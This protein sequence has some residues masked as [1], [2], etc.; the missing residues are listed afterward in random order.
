MKE[1]VSIVLQNINKCV[2]LHHNYFW[3]T[4][5]LY[6]E[7][8]HLPVNSTLQGGKYRIV[9]FIKSGGFGCTYEAVDTLMNV[10]VAIKEFFVKDFCNRDETTY[11]IT[12]ATESKRELVEKLRR[13]FIDEARAIF[14]MK[15]ENIVRVYGVFEENGTAYYVMDYID[16]PSLE[17]IVKQYGFLSETEA[18]GYIRQVAGA[19]CYVHSQNRLHLDIKPG[20][21]LVD[22]RGKAILIDFGASK[23]YDE[24]EGENKSTLL[25]QTPGYAPIEQM[26]N[27]VQKFHPST[28]IYALGATL[29][30]LLTGITPPKASDL[31]AGV[32]S[33][34]PLPAYVSENVRNAVYK[35][36]QKNME[37]RPQS[38]DQFLRMIE[39]KGEQKTPPSTTH[40]VP[41]N[42]KRFLGVMA[43]VAAVTL[44]AVLA[45]AYIGG[46]DTSEDPQENEVKADTTTKVIPEEEDEE[47]YVL[48]DKLT[49][50]VGDVEFNMILVKGGTF[51]MGAENGRDHECDPAHDVT[52]DDYYIAETEVTQEL[53]EAVKQDMPA[54]FTGNGKLPMESV[55]GDD[56]MSFLHELSTELGKQFRLPTEAEW[57]FAA[58]GGNKS[59][60]YEYS[61]S[62]YIAKV[63]W[64]SNW[65]YED[66]PG[67][68][69]DKTHPV[70]SLDPNELGI[71][72]MSGN[73][74]EWC[75]D[76]QADY[77][78]GSQVNPTGPSSGPN[79]VRRGGSW[80]DNAENCTVYYR[81]YSTIDER[82]GACGFRIVLP[83]SEV[84]K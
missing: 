59:N 21:I 18:I 45:V 32:E 84:R 34:K 16:G 79:R 62:N 8:M 28:D 73:V 22:D 6:T 50:Y 51:V 75:S 63:A 49:F 54:Y 38:I 52:L 2:T 12:L 26:G 44:A 37:K 61:G 20:N 67:N 58:R 15:H 83:V 4:L 65:G 81:Q 13:K 78:S 41:F 1:K 68:S 33:L 17:D 10:R 29:Y 30:K 56:C 23:Q 19:L 55:T 35:S 74:M 82:Q 25:G 57:E 71:Y 27:N 42:W 80:C 48:E 24:E 76:W 39:G 47:E 64:Y 53:W 46:R 11:R 60:G 69:N 66:N 9:R 43:M 77:S 3:R 31:V 70:A 72:D 40:D 36:L 5:R 7:K 14:N